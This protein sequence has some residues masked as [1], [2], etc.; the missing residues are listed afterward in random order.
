MTNMILGAS[1]FLGDTVGG[2]SDYFR[3]LA[4]KGRV[5]GEVWACRLNGGKK[6]VEAETLNRLGIV[7]LFQCVI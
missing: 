5:W 6:G 2:A 3:G 7:L 4:F 1:W